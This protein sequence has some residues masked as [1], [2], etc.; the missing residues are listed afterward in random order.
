M[1]AGAYGGLDRRL[2]DSGGTNDVRA[3]DGVSSLTIESRSGDVQTTSTCAMAW[4]ES[5]RRGAISKE[6]G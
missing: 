5:V 2:F 6:F 1:P 3:T 4:A